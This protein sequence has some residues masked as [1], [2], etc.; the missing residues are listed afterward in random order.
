MSE[1]ERQVVVE[2]VYSP[3]GNRV[4]VRQSE[5][6]AM[7]GS[8]HLADA[9]RERPMTGT[10]L[11]VGPDVRQLKVGDQVMFARFAG[12][13][14]GKVTGKADLEA[15]LVLHEGEEILMSYGE[16]S[17]PE[18]AE[19]AEARLADQRAKEARSAPFLARLAALSGD[20]LARVPE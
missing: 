9:S 14:V 6:K 2:T 10:V 15:I 13:S 3:I 8:L 18:T 16:A 17:R 4:V 19:E 5:A 20:G 1:P 11:A 12:I 7:A